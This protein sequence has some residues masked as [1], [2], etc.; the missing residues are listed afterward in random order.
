MYYVSWY[1]V[2]RNTVLSLTALRTLGGDVVLATNSLMGDFTAGCALVWLTFI[3]TW[4]SD[5]FAYFV[6]CSIG[7]HRLCET[8]SPKKAL[9]DLLAVL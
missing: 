6:G 3:G 8:I 5:T 9:K 7:K 2:Y 1:Y 4:A